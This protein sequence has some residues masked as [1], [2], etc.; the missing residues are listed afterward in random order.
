MFAL[1]CYKQYYQKKGNSAVVH[2]KEQYFFFSNY[3]HLVIVFTAALSP[4]IAIH[5]DTSTDTFHK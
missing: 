3:Q 5:S 1:Y 4:S 2:L